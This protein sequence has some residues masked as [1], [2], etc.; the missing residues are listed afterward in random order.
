MWA[1][2][3]VTRLEFGYGSILDGSVFY[4]GLCDS[5]AELKANNGEIYY[6]HDYMDNQ[7]ND[8][9]QAERWKVGMNLK[10]REIEIDKIIK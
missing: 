7:E 3:E 9:D 10:Q 4:I 2:G 6:S 5:C 8:S 1:D